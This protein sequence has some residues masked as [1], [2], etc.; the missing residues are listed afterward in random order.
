[1][2]VPV[3]WRCYGNMLFNMEIE[4][5]KNYW[6]KSWQRIKLLAEAQKLY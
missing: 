3:P 6:P 4:S 2:A 5:E 1:M